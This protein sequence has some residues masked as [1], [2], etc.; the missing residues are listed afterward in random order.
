MMILQFVIVIS[1]IFGMEP[2]RKEFLKSIMT[3]TVWIILNHVTIKH[4]YNKVQIWNLY[5]ASRQILLE[6]KKM[7]SDIF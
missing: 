4:A 3:H 5:K 7:I 1:T 2:S 6:T